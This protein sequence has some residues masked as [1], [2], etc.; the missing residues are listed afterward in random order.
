M[1]RVLPFLVLLA[2]TAVPALGQSGFPEKPDPAKKMDSGEYWGWVEECARR[3]DPKGVDLLTEITKQYVADKYHE[4]IYSAIKTRLLDAEEAVKR[5]EDGAK[6]KLLKYQAEVETLAKAIRNA[7]GDATEVEWIEMYKKMTPEARKEMAW[8]DE[9]IDQAKKVIEHEKDYN[10]G[11][12]RAEAGLGVYRKYGDKVRIAKALQVIAECE[13]HLKNGPGAFAALTEARTLLKEAGTEPELLKE[14]ETK[15]AEM[16][17]AAEAGGGLSIEKSALDRDDSWEVDKD[18]KPKWESFP[19]QPGGK[20]PKLPARIPSAIQRT[21]YFF[22]KQIYLEDGR[23][24]VIGAKPGAEKL[25]LPGDHWFVKTPGEHELMIT[26]DPDKP[27]LGVKFKVGFSP[28][29]EE[30]K[31]QYPNP[32]PKPGAP[33]TIT[34]PYY[35]EVMGMKEIQMFGL[36][37]GVA[38]P[39]NILDLRAHGLAWRTGKGP[40][41]QSFTIIDGNFNGVFGIKWNMVAGLEAES[42]IGNDGFVAGNAKLGSVFSPLVRMGKGYY[43]CEP[44]KHSF[45]CAF[46]KYKGPTA[47]LQVKMKGFAGGVKPLWLIVETQFTWKRDKKEEVV[48]AQ[49]DI[50]DA[51][52]GPIDIPPGGWTLVH[53]VVADGDDEDSANRA[54]IRPGTFPKFVAKAGETTVIELGGPFTPDVAVEWDQGKNEA[55]LKTMTLQI[56]GAK[57]EIYHSLWPEVWEYDYDIK[58]SRGATMDSGSARKLGERD[59]KNP[60]AAMGFAKQAVIRGKS[61]FQPPFWAAIKGSHKLFGA[62]A[63]TKAPPPPAPPSE[64]AEGGKPP[65]EGGDGHGKS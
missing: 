11:K 55:T 25:P 29:L 58:D 32:N 9:R 40:G 12:Q 39:P 33:S 3:G 50:A 60:H 14:I 37:A 38:N 15:V 30:L 17:K 19:M 23:K 4:I 31:V 18:G 26:P 2:L 61:G 1:R 24:G 13:E 59:E 42:D 16:E 65:A 22:W 41:G 52:R 34:I 7:T 21:H 63:R 64:A 28:S 53:G 56:H 57:G 10:S 47:K 6:E 20:Q 49:I 27:L 36:K 8:A 46:R 44:A 35:Y 51:T 45:E 54:D 5:D 48:R 62:I 43:L